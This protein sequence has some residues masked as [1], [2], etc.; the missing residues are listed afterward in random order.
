MSL[1]GKR[2]GF[3]RADFAALAKAASLKRGRGG[4]I[5]DE[6]RA[7]VAGWERHAASRPACPSEVAA[8]IGR[9]HR[10]LDS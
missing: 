10:D 2:E 5:L 3:E 4:A 1:N 7:A 8:A 6:V 9:G